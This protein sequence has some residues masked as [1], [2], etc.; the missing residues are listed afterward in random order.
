MSHSIVHW[1]GNKWSFSGF[2][3]E[4][5]SNKNRA[6]LVCGGPSLSTI[7][8]S[9]L[10]GPG[11]AVFGLN[12]TYPYVVP[13]YWIGMDDPRCY[14]RNVL[15]EG[16][17]K[18]LRGGLADRNFQGVDPKELHNVHFINCKSG[19]QEEIFARAKYASKTFIWQNNVMAV[20]MNLLLAMG[21]KEIYIIGCD[22]DNSK[23]DYFEGDVKLGDKAKERNTRLYGN[24]YNWLRWLTD[25]CAKK[26]IK[27]HTLSKE[28]KIS[29]FMPYMSLLDLNKKV[30]QELPEP[31]VLYNAFDLQEMRRQKGAPEPK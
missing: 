23:Q 22:F 27:L 10:R 20:A 25:E 14:D 12:N 26:D 19:P 30:E 15:F 31:G 18:F 3:R 11:K 16:F 9:K 5:N 8:V 7:D 2:H 4:P 28:S 29:K 6:I 17:P 24:L 21:F 13:D 1:N